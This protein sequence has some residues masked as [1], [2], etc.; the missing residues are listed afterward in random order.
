MYNKLIYNEVIII[1]IK[2]RPQQLDL[3]FYH[4]SHLGA[5]D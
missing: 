4:A 5:L 1:I 2:F 3:D